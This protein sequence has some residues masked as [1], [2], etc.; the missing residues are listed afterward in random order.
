HAV[1][2][3]ATDVGY[4]LVMTDPDAPSRS[5]PKMGEWRHW[6]VSRQRHVGLCEPPWDHLVCR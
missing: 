1:V 3:S 4:T 6:L 2:C 5:D